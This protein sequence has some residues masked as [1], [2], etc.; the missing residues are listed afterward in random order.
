MAISNSSPSKIVLRIA[1]ALFLIV[2]GILTLQLDS[3]FL[4]KL[5]AGFSGN[6]IATAVHSFLKGDMANVVIVCLGILELVAGLFL[7]LEFF[8]DTRAFSGLALL[9]ILIL[10]IVVIVLV[11]VIGKGGLLD[12][13]FKSSA[14]FLSFLKVLG[15]HLL[16]LGAIM[17]AQEK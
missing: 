4:G 7:I 15:A 13:A 2:T 1:L 14:A 16:V 11:D 17:S 9:V 3:G 12:G 6:E 8:M 5:Q 10:W